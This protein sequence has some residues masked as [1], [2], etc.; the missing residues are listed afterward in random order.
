MGINKKLKFEPDYAVLPGDSLLE[1]LE[2]LGMSQADLAE[3]TG[4]TTKT[5]NEIIKGKAPIT[6]ETALQFE[7]VFGTPATFWNNRERNY[8]ETLAR[9]EEKKRLSQDFDWFKK[10]PIKD[11]T[12][13]GFIRDIA[14]KTQSIAD[15]LNFFGVSS[16]ETWGNVW[17]GQRAAFRQSKV[18][19]SSPE[20]ISAWLRTGEI[21]AQQMDCVPFNREIF[22]KT[23][24]DIRK[25]CTSKPINT[26]WLYMV[27]ACMQAGV[28]LVCMP[29][30]GKVHVSGATHW[31]TPDKTIIQVSFRHK[32]DD[33]FWFTFFH[34]AGHIIKHG[35]KEGFIDD[36]SFLGEKE[37][38]ANQF[39]ADILITP[40]AFTAFLRNKITKESVRAFAHEIGVSTGVVVGRLQHEGRLRRDAFN[41]LKTLLTK[42]QIEKLTGLN[43]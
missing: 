27:K 1:I 41:D 31:V 9:L 17:R 15:V 29:G 18:F 32:S 30:I 14:D 26:T 3:R 21:R 7:R 39:A 34:E 4:R 11:L 8:R 35:K 37:R 10:L 20:A 25:N 13:L 5:I 43:P 33:H 23:L 16:S 38:E 42:V 24:D 36:G 22:I 40:K 12:R 6:P 28:A 19:Q 2:H